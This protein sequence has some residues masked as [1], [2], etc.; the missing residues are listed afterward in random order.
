MLHIKLMGMEHDDDDDDRAPCKH[1]FCPFTHAR[2]WSKDQN[3]FL[4][5]VVMLHIKL[6]GIEHR[7]SFKHYSART[8]TPSTPRW[9]QKV[10]TFLSSESKCVAYHSKKNGT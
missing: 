9:G 10:K 2:P 7:A 8:H 5:K 3:I 4:L 6:K 1:I